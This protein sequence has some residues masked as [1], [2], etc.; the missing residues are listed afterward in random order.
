MEQDSVSL[1]DYWRLL[2]NNRNY[3]R[4]WFAQIIS[5]IGDWLYTL[6]IYSM[7]LEYT[8]SA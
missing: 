2:R 6:A 3:R 7:I 5:E 4:L 8:G 1:G